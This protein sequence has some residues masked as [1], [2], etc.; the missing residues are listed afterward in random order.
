MKKI[1]SLSF[2]LLFSMSLFAQEI[3]LATG[4]TSFLE[5][6]FADSYHINHL[7]GSKGWSMVNG[8]GGGLHKNSDFYALDW[9]R[10]LVATC[11]VD[12]KAPLSG[13]VIWTGGSDEGYGKQIIIQSDQDSTF[14]FRIAHLEA[15]TARLGQIV[16]IG[17][18]I[19]RIGDT[20]N[21][22]CHGHL[23]LY[24]KIYDRINVPKTS[25]DSLL[26]SKDRAIDVLKKGLFIS[27]PNSTKNYFAAPFRF[28]ESKDGFD[29]LRFSPSRPDLGN[30]DTLDVD[31]QLV[32][33]GSSSRVGELMLSLQREKEF[34]FYQRP[35]EGQ[36][37]QII[38]LP[39]DTVTIR[40]EQL[41]F[42]QEPGAYFLHLLLSDADTID[43]V[44]V[45][46]KPI[47]PI[48]RIP[49]EVYATDL[50]KRDEPNNQL[51]T[52][53][54]LYPNAI[55][56]RAA[57]KTKEAYIS[58]F[59]DPQDVYTFSSQALGRFELDV[60]GG[61]FANWNI[62]TAESSVEILEEDGIRYFYTRPNETYYLTV[63]GPSSCLK[64]YRFSYNWT[65]VELLE[66]DFIATDVLTHE[67][68]VLEPVKTE[69]MIFDGLGRRLWNSGTFDL[70]PGN[71]QFV[72]EILLPQTGVYYVVLFVNGKVSDQ[73]RFF[74]KD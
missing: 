13:K 4:G 56:V 25:A 28:L 51:N 70:A 50:C 63:T 5:W 68:E 48:G 14:A 39:N 19:G 52:A 30:E 18:V 71:H 9:L 45:N 26:F 3:K 72:D 37:G 69:R 33:R 22:P 61:S 44:P 58:S 6:P 66:W 64:P 7:S 27:S 32:N 62:N 29:L 11:G 49:I 1:I 53:T 47:T 24:Q 43:G 67:I 38:F 41:F 73:R 31:I 55:A 65:A 59:N 2:L 54:P 35:L 57:K 34:N 17:D 60:L 15:I 40:Q 20:G 36:S 8:A 12:F 74:W 42:G 16:K 10:P 23:V 46:P 21:G